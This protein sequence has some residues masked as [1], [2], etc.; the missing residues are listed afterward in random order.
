MTAF[1]FSTKLTRSK[2]N[3]NEIA[4]IS[5]IMHR[6]L[7]QDGPTKDSQFQS[8]TLLRKLDQLP[9]PFDLQSKLRQRK[10]SNIHVF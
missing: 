2:H 7:N 10:D 4:M 9:L 5:C 8:F 6:N 1:C 3:T